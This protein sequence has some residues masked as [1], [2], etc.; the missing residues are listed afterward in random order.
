MLILAVAAACALSLLSGGRLGNIEGSR[1]RGFLLPV[2]ALALERAAALLCP[3]V[4]PRAP[5]FAVFT[6]GAYLLCILFIF[7][8]RSYKLFAALAGAGTLANLA[9][10]A[11]NDFYMP[12]SE[13]AMA[14]AGFSGIP[15]GL[16]AAYRVADGATRLRALGDMLYVPLPLVGG[17]A[18][19]GDVLL[20]AGIFVFVFQLMRA[21][22]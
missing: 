8:N 19:A 13:R 1:A 2:A 17:F 5:W 14:L 7:I 6:A 22:R 16:Q 3:G 4:L 15:R 10:I 18:S 12:V 11:A 21:K 9:V 20:A